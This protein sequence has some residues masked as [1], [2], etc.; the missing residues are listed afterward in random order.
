MVTAAARSI[1]SHRRATSLAL[2][3][4]IA[5]LFAAGA[6]AQDSTETTEDSAAHPAIAVTLDSSE[7]TPVPVPEEELAAFR[8]DPEFDYVEKVT[9]EGES[10][11]SRILR[12]INEALIDLMPDGDS[13]FLDLF[14]MIGLAVA[15]V[16]L[17]V[18]ISGIGRS[19]MRPAA[20]LTSDMKEID[21]NIHEMDFEALIA[22]AVGAGRYRRAVRL[23]YLR[24]LK[25]MT[26]RGVIEW[27]L[28]RTNHDYMRQ[29]GASAPQALP[30]FREATLAFEYVW[31]GDLGVDSTKFERIW[32]TFEGLDD[33]IRQAPVRTAGTAA[34]NQHQRTS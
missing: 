12:E 2:C 31:Y 34:T 5:P 8:D 20:R 27:R 11:L 28:D 32:R 25:K 17:V 10:F 15:A 13:S 33:T 7:I 9:P 6:L 29:L 24:S 19:F 14:T 22:E 3:L 26:D 1:I 4:A 16:I 18:L 30:P 21:E 23:L